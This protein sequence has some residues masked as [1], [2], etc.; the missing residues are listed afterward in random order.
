MTSKSPY[1]LMAFL[2]LGT[3]LGCIW[4][5]K[6]KGPH[7]EA[8]TI[9]SVQDRDANTV[10]DLLLHFGK[11]ISEAHPLN[12]FQGES[13][14]PLFRLRS[15]VDKALQDSAT[16]NS[17]LTVMLGDYF[18][19]QGE[20][21]YQYVVNNVI[22]I[23]RPDMHLAYLHLICRDTEPGVCLALSKALLKEVE[24]FYAKHN[25]DI[26]RDA[27]LQLANQRDS[28]WNV[29][30]SQ[31]AGLDS[32]QMK[33]LMALTHTLNL[34][35]LEADAALHRQKSLLWVVETPRWPLTTAGLPWWQPVMAGVGLGLMA[36][37]VYL[38]GWW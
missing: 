17:G 21:A 38:K 16:L 29:M 37:L 27:K 18:A 33:S 36:G 32:L 14:M 34:Q 22:E 20:G 6:A 24:A 2:L 5:W 10:R 25:R 12:I 26:I 1:S 19:R 15:V 8:K 7:Y 28:L 23:L 4:A 11:D 9:F 3:A 31:D 30:A 35:I 13:L